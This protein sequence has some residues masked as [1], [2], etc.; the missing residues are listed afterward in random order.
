MGNVKSYWHCFLSISINNIFLWSSQWSQ[1][2]N[3]VRQWLSNMHFC[4]INNEVIHSDRHS[5]I[6]ITDRWILHII[7]GSLLC[8]FRGWC[9]IK[10]VMLHCTNQSPD[11]H[12]LHY[13]YYGAIGMIPRK[14]L[15]QFQ[16]TVFICYFLDVVL[17]RKLQK[18]IYWILNVFA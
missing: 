16:S 9:P 5:W 2:D 11:N 15:R 3:I 1:T 6:I 14:I 12:G 4:C 17:R 7:S 13:C 10:Q 8:C 18:C